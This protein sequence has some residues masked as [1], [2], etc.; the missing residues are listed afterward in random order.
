MLESLKRSPWLAVSL[1]IAGMV[2]GYVFQIH[3]V[4]ATATAGYFCPNTQACANGEC[5]KNVDCKN[6]NC[7]HC[8][9]CQGASQ[10]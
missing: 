10:S 9:G 2:L 8:P 4:G 7:K 1:V 5:D 6:G 3:R